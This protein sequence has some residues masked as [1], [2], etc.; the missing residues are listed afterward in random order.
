MDME[1]GSVTMGANRKWWRC[2]GGD[3]L[4]LPAGDADGAARLEETTVEMSSSS[5]LPWPEMVE[6]LP[7]L[8]GKMELLVGDEDGG[9]G[10]ILLS[11]S[12]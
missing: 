4:L 5:W 10:I 12:L 11:P 6:T 7:D 9:I 1:M 3:G 2:V 8:T